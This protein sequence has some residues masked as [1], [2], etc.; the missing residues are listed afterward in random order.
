[1]NYI[2]VLILANNI[3]VTFINIVKAQLI[4]PQCHK[5]IHCE[6]AHPNH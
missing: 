4:V 6:Y 2:N 3:F 5:S 1:M